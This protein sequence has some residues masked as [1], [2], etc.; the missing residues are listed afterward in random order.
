MADEIARR[1]HK[2]EDI[3]QSWKLFDTIESAIAVKDDGISRENIRRNGK[4]IKQPLE[5]SP[6][7]SGGSPSARSL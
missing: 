6:E 5:K 2:S 7:R 4:P 3:G 1:Y